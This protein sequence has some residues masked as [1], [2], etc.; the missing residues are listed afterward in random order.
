MIEISWLRP[1]ITYFDIVTTTIPT[2][3]HYVQEF[4]SNSA[5]KKK[6]SLTRKYHNPSIPSSATNEGS[7]S[8]PTATARNAAFSPW[9][10]QPKFYCLKRPAERTR[11][12]CTPETKQKSQ[13]FVTSYSHFVT[14]RPE[15]F[16]QFQWHTP[17]FPGYW[18]PSKGMCF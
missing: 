3:Y 2:E 15:R 4:P 6:N 18:H 12:K 16:N 13:T 1:K 14:Q 9:K 8:P 11:E 7:L 10:V 5:Q 17:L